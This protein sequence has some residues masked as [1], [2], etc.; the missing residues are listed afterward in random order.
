MADTPSH[1]LGNNF[2][3]VENQRRGAGM[4]SWFGEIPSDRGGTGLSDPMKKDGVIE[5]LPT[6]DFFGHVR[7]TPLALKLQADQKASVLAEKRK[8]MRLPLIDMLNSVRTGSIAFR[9]TSLSTPAKLL[10]I[11]AEQRAVTCC[12]KAASLL[13]KDYVLAEIMAQAM[14]LEKR[15]EGLKEAKRE[16][17]SDEDDIVETQ[18]IYRHHH[19]HYHHH[20]FPFKTPIPRNQKNVVIPCS[21]PREFAATTVDS[22]LED[23]EVPRSGKNAQERRT[24][25]DRLFGDDPLLANEDFADEIPFS[26]EHNHYHTHMNKTVRRPPPSQQKIESPRLSE[27]PIIPRTPRTKTKPHF[28]RKYFRTLKGKEDF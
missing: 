21:R 2:A 15:E 22:H 24:K 10:K 1:A 27:G 14:P 16:E 4:G 12:M 6:A 23:C 7:D 25:K 3:Y 26:H 11:K 20:W 19:H 9:D 5:T 28:R 13:A 17:E 8:K 18:I